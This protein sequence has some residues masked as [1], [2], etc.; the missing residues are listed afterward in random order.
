MSIRAQYDLISSYMLVSLCYS[1]HPE[2]LKCQPKANPS[3]CLSSAQ[4]NALRNLYAPYYLGPN[5]QSYV[6]SPFVPGAEYA[7]PQG[8]VGETPFHMPEDYYRYFV[9][10]D[11]TWQ[12]TQLDEAV[13]SMGIEIN[14]GQMDVSLIGI[15]GVQARPTQ[16]RFM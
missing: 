7:Y 12:D 11:T 2:T 16:E 10:N 8:L 3:T 5:N 9:L 4:L 15:F 1:F 6:F 13:V 14:P